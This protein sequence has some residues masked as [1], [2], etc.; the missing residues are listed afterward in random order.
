MLR[1]TV[2]EGM[3]DH[4]ITTNYGSS[5]LDSALMK[6]RGLPSSFQMGLRNM[7]RKKGRSASTILQITLAVGMFLA[8]ASIGHSIQT[9]VS[10]EFGNFT[11][12]IITTGSTE[13]AR[14]L[15]EGL[16]SI[17]GGTGCNAD[18]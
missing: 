6:L 15:S 18:C 3:E 14:P 5:R 8:I 4:G 17:L 9:A 11:C 13:G 2:R 7:A 1:V 16:Q 12:D 10:Q